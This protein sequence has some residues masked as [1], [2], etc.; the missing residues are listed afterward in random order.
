[1]GLTFYQKHQGILTKYLSFL[2]VAFGEK[3]HRFIQKR[4]HYAHCAFIP[5]VLTDK[6]KIEELNQCLSEKWDHDMPLPSYFQ[7]EL[8]R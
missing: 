7:D 8:I 5:E 3:K 4:S 1:M 6:N 2:D